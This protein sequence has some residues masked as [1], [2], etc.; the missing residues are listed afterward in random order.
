M[1][2]LGRGELQ[3]RVNCEGYEEL[4]AAL[5]LAAGSAIDEGEMLVRVCPLLVGEPLLDRAVQAFRRIEVVAVLVLLEPG[6]ER[7]GPL[8][9]LEEA[10]DTLAGRSGARGKRADCQGDQQPARHLNL[11]RIFT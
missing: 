8:A 9:R 5:A 7:G 6:A 1:A 3:F 11:C 4:I 10:L 2:G